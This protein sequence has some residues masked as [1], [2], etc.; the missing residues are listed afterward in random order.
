MFQRHVL[1]NIEVKTPKNV[2]RRPLYDSARLVRVLQEVLRPE[3]DFTFISSFDHEWIRLY[4]ESDFANFIFL[5]QRE[6]TDLLP[7]DTDSW[8]QG[9][10]VQLTGASAEN[11]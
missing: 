2:A 7:D 1:V 5:H 10:N 3:V 9:C 6:P 4:Q 11:I 8:G